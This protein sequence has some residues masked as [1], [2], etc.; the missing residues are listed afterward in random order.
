MAKTQFSLT[1]DSKLLGRPRGF[2]ITVREVR[3]SA[4]AGFIVPMTGTITTMPGLPRDPAAEKMDI[5]ANGK[6]SGLF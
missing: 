5:D 4:G 1:D 2:K 6:I 3:I